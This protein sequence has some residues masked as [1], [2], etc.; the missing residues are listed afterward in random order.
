MD[1]KP[2][3]GSPEEIEDLKKAYLDTKGSIGEIMTHIPHSTVDDEPRFIVEITKLIQQGDLPEMKEWQKSIKDE[4]ARLIRQ[5]ESQK[6]ASEAEALAKELG[7]WDEFYGDGKPRKRKGKGKGKGMQ[8]QEDDVDDTAALQALI[9]RR[10][11]TG[12]QAM[13]SFFDSLEAKYAGGT[14]KKGK[15]KKR[16][17]ADVEDE[18][19]PSTKKARV[20]DI[21]DDEFAKIQERL[22]GD[23]SKRS[24]ASV[25]TASPRKASSRK[26]GRKASAK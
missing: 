22:F 5:K 1:L 8:A 24:K 23:G 9:T 10:K 6:E 16:G 25:S 19:G 2:S 12:A 7:V 3:K 15:A 17:H 21:P 14:G 13:S 20:E 11:E 4:K 26:K 18:G